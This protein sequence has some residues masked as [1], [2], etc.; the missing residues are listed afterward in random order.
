MVES[1][2]SGGRAHYCDVEVAALVVASVG[3]G[4]DDRK[5]GENTAD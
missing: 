2:N 1:V 4:V 5:R 3:R